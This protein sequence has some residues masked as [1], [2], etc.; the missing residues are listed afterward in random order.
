M[1]EVINSL[2]QSNNI[3]IILSLGIVSTNIYAVLK[4][5]ISLCKL[6][7][8]N[9]SIIKKYNQENNDSAE[10]QR[11]IIEEN[12]NLFDKKYA[13]YFKRILSNLSDS[14]LSNVG[15]NI[16][17]LKF[18]K[19]SSEG[20]LELLTRGAIGLYKGSTNEIYH[21][22]NHSI[23]HEILHMC[24]AYYDRKNNIYY[25]G[26]KQWEKDLS[27]G[28]G[29]NEGYTE[30][31]ASKI[32]KNHLSIS[33]TNLTNL[34]KT[35][36][37]F[38]SDPKELEHLYFNNNLNGLIHHLENYAERNDLIRMIIDMDEILAYSKVGSP[39]AIIKSAQVQAKLYNMYAS[40]INDI[41]ALE[42]MKKYVTKNPLTRL[43]INKS[44]MKLTRKNP[45]EYKTLEEDNSM[46]SYKAR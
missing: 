45:F 13:P 27:I 14:D 2:I 19:N 38:F 24:S 4:N 23:T 46:E 21:I 31:L 32:E 37:F 11:E 8:Y 18:N 41:D 3:G 15:R 22:G 39:L 30:Y 6:S 44:K 42:E 5:K 16:L 17:S 36:E 40:K 20:I 29:L 34:A 10:N 7:K 26:F 25:S 43:L 9:G 28:T 1:Q 33:Y 12:I 35:I